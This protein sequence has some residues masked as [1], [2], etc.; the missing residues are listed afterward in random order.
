[1]PGFFFLEVL[2]RHLLGIHR[3]HIRGVGEVGDRLE[4]LDGI[5]GQIVGAAGGIDRHCR[6]RR[7]GQHVAIGSRLGG[8]GR[9]DGAARAALVFDHQGLAELLAHALGDQAGDDVGGAA[10]SERHDHA[11]GM[12]GILVGSLGGRGKGPR[13]QR[14]RCRQRADFHH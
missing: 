11:Y 4:I 12:A 1:L 8:F 5:V 7:D 14:D 2:D 3:H 10:G 13:A 9:A 6:H